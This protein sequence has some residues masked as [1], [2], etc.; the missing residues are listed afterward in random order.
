MKNLKKYF[1]FL[2][3]FIFIILSGC[4]GGGSSGGR[5]DTT[6]PTVVST[7][8][9]PDEIGVT[10]ITISVT[11][12]EAMSKSTINTTTF[13]VK[14]DNRTI[15]GKVTYSDSE[16][17]ATFTPSSNLSPLST[18]TVTIVTGVKDLAGNAMASNYTWSFT[19]RDGTWGTASLISE[20][21]E[22]IN[23]F[24][25]VA[26]DS[27]GNAIVLWQQE[28]TNYYIMKTSYA[29]TTQKWSS[30]YY[31]A[32]GLYSEQLLYP[33]IAMNQDG[34]AFAVWQKWDDTNLIYNIFAKSSTSFN[35]TIQPTSIENSLEDAEY[36][37]IGID[38][39]GNAIAIWEQYD[40][41][42]SL[43]IY[44]RR[45]NG[46]N[47]EDEIP[48][49]GNDITPSDD[50]Y[51]L[52]ADIAVDS[53]GNATVVWEQNFGIYASSYNV[54]NGTWSAAIP[55]DSGTG[56]QYP[57]VAMDSNGNAIAVW[58]ADNFVYA[59]RYDA[60]TL[61]WQSAVP[62]QT[63]LVG[64]SYYPKIA[65]D[66]NGNA[67]AVWE[68]D[69]N[70][71]YAA[72]YD[73][74]L[75]WSL[76]VSIESSS[77]DAFNAQVAMDANGNAIAVWEQDYRIYAQRYVAQEG[78]WGAEAVPIDDGT[79]LAEFSQIAMDVNGNATVVWE[80]DYYIYANRFEFK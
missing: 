39:N 72:Y 52:R 44:A 46:S 14:K 1:L 5:T 38:T 23:E 48:P 64:Y 74:N 20:G 60:D 41:F 30:S 71:I 58:E 47:W 67:I 27:R 53:N 49:L 7:N 73:A 19:T 62:I 80:Q 37:Q 43:N 28:V 57:Q 17:K 35:P 70:K 24:P 77:E 42:L 18:Y 75:G 2:S 65:M 13:I 55:I 3:L 63:D 29:Y 45:Y 32:W 9:S 61:T 36:P 21:S 79:G 68:Q 25:S 69:N 8:P 78:T 56:G 12:S 33:R 11:F 76:S 22:G 40:E 54:S 6:P 51:N 4:G 31:I 66:A 16:K 10:S 26:M 34:N 15:I 50:P 59:A